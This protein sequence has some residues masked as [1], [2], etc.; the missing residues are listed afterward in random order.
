MVILKC[1]DIIL[2]IL[3][4]K[5]IGRFNFEILNFNP[6]KLSAFSL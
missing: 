1:L 5:I 3:N 6:Q 2:A 4:G